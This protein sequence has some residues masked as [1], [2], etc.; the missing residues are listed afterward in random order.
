MDGDRNFV[1]PLG[2]VERWTPV[3]AAVEMSEYEV[4][5]ALLDAGADPNELCFGHTLLTHSIDVEGDGHLQSGHLLNTAATAILLAYGA[6]PRL[7]AT[8]GEPPL[9]IAEHYNHEPA[10]RLLQRF[11]ARSETA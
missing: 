6:D 10:M 7:P 2:D 1:K 11:L 8:D 9:Q 5:T 3:H 4:L